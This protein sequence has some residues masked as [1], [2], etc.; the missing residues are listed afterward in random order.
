MTPKAKTNIKAAAITLLIVVI[1]V[2]CLIGI[3]L[4]IAGIAWLFD[5]VSIK[6]ASIGATCFLGIALL[7]LIFLSVKEN[8]KVDMKS[9]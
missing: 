7:Y 2:G 5:K 4:V 1:V 3:L 8:I 6:T 9:K